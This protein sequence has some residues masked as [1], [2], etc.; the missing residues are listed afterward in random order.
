MEKALGKGLLTEKMTEWLRGAG[1][2]TCVLRASPGSHAVIAQE[3]WRALTARALGS[4]DLP[5]KEASA[6]QRKEVT[7]YDVDQHS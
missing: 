2:W 7:I 3:L 1:A 6:P 4:P 5:G